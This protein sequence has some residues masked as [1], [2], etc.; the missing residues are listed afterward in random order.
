MA[1]SMSPRTLRRCSLALLILSL[2]GYYASARV[3]PALI[4][5]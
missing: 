2:L 1:A 4:D 3:R 5:S